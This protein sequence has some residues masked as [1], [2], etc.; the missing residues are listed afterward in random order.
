MNKKK[1]KKPGDVYTFK[2]SDIRSGT[3]QLFIWLY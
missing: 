2:K 3:L 1:E